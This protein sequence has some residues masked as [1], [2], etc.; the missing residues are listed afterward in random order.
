MEE[1]QRTDQILANISERRRISASSFV[2]L[3][4]T[5]W[6]GCLCVYSP[7]AAF[8]RSTLPPSLREVAAVDPPRDGCQ[9]ELSPCRTP[10]PASA[11]LPARRMS[12][13]GEQNQ[14]W[15]TEIAGN[16]PSSPS[17]VR[18]GGNFPRWGK[19]CSPQG[20]EQ[21]YKQKQIAAESTGLPVLSL[22]YP[23]FPDDFWQ[24]KMRSPD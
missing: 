14:A 21:R 18:T 12:D 9:K 20:S 1:P 16:S 6:W 3:V 4:A 23:I 2:L 10:P 17:S 15:R 7:G 13:E 24:L 19:H 11:N 8:G 22:F 5:G